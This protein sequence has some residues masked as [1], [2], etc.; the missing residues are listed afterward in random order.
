MPTR[1]DA[2]ISYSHSVD[3]KLA[4]AL[5]ECTERLAKPILKLRAADVFRDETSLAA[6]PSLWSGIQDHLCGSEWFVLLACPESAGSP[7]CTKE[8][9]CWLENRPVG[10]MLIVLTG[11]DLVWDPVQQ[12]FDWTQTT[13][14]NKSLSGKFPD[15]PLYLDLRWTKQHQSLTLSDLKFRDAVLNLAAPI[16]AVRKD[17]LDGA[18]VRQLRRSRQLVRIGVTAICIAAV[19]A[20]WQA[21]VATGQRNEAMRQTRIALSN[22]LSSIAQQ[23]APS[24]TD[25]ALL[26]AVHAVRLD[27]SFRSRSGL[28]AALQAQPR[29]Q[30]LLHPPDLA[31]TGE[32]SLDG[33]RFVTA[34]QG[35]GVSIWDTARWERVVHIVDAH[36]D[37]IW[38]LVFLPDGKSLATASLDKTVAVWDLESGKPIGPR[39]RGHSDQ[40]LCAAVSPDGRILAT[41]GLDATIRLWDLSQ[42]HVVRVI[43]RAHQ[44]GVLSLAFSPDGTKFLSG[45]FEGAIR[46]WD[47]ASGEPR[48]GPQKLHQGAVKRLAFQKDGS[49]LASAGADGAIRFWNP[50]TWEPDGKPFLEYDRDVAGLAFS[51]D[52]KQLAAGGWNGGV[53]LWNLGPED[54]ISRRFFQQKDRVLQVAFSPDGRLLAAV[55]RN[56]VGL[57]DT[58]GSTSF[59][60]E[61][62]AYSDE[63]EAVAFSPGGNVLAIG[64]NQGNVYLHPLENPRDR[65]PLLRGNGGEV[66]GLQYSPSGAVLAAGTV[67]GAVQLWDVL[68]RKLIWKDTIHTAG[69]FGLAF[70]PDER[71]LVSA[72]GDGFVVRRDVATGHVMGSPVQA[73]L[74]GA[75][76]AVVAF[77]PHDPYFVSAGRGGDVI[78][79]DAQTGQRIRVL[80]KGDNDSGGFDA[81]TFSPDGR[82]LIA[83]TGAWA[84]VWQAGNW[85][86]YGKQTVGEKRFITQVA[87][88]SDSRS[89]VAKEMAAGGESG[90]HFWDAESKRIMSEPLKGPRSVW[91]MS[92]SPQGTRI[93]ASFGGGFPLQVWSLETS[94][95]IERACRIANR[96]L[97]PTEWTELVGRLPQPSIC[98]P[99]RRGVVSPGRVTP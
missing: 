17:E 29:L 4:K 48:A 31:M 27:P 26:L 14:L 61:L 35:G 78:L 77:G 49:R 38:A 85:E 60:Q 7:W 28:L 5:E 70:S 67:D 72:G 58:D 44:G 40:V 90:I 64:D 43:A 41:G 94:E 62:G 80:V 18:D 47:A 57:W 76:S 93:A 68:G 66:V 45:G 92:L 75:G 37:E 34:D 11:G 22:A 86:N 81:V 95:W 87:F 83:A 23:K 71:M 15:E 6:N 24:E 46:V 54:E 88:P 36:Q 89:P 97:R 51:P 55:S 79:W 3:S 82:K 99:D 63:V 30:R 25:V 52:G 39:M 98:P 10:R 19:V 8:A 69:V 1:H 91:H 13:S 12:D 16:R 32:F 59:P 84:Y 42:R 65:G 50:R 33:K 53:T 2:F 20:I 73:H 96:D 9:S 56:T 74:R 21:I